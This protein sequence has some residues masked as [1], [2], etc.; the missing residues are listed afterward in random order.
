MIIS[1]IKSLWLALFEKI[2]FVPKEPKK[3]TQPVEDTEHINY[4]DIAA[5]KVTNLTCVEATNEVVSESGL[6]EPLMDISDK[7]MQVKEKIVYGVL[8]KGGFFNV[9]Y[10]DGTGR[11]Q[12]MSLTNDYVKI[13]SRDGDNIKEAYIILE[14]YT[15]KNQ[16]A[17]YFLM[18]H[19]VLENNGDLKIDYT[20][21][22]SS[23]EKTQL[24]FTN[25][26]P[27]MWKRNIDSVSVI[28]NAKHIGLGYYRSPVQGRNIPTDEGVPLDFG[29]SEIIAELKEL[30]TQLNNE[31][32]NGKS[33]IFADD[34]ILVND[35][36]EHRF[37]IIENIFPSHRKAGI[38]GNMIEVYSPSIRFQQFHEREQA[39]YADLEN[40]MKLSRG[41]FT[42]NTIT[43]GATATEVKRSNKDTI[44]LIKSLH[45]MLDK[46]DEM[47]LEACGIYLNIRRELWEYQS[48]YYDPFDDA[49]EQWSYLKAAYDTG[50]VSLKRLTK[51]IYPNMTDEEVEEELKAAASE[52]QTETN[53][54]IM[55]ALNM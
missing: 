5:G 48:D 17:T 26:I 3:D 50:A 12:L 19:H 41:I 55:Q 7:L 8:T 25:K 23:A 10:Y 43:T 21:M 1:K 37:K 18:R 46:G 49:G 34:R 36:K 4:L 13:V 44:A 47:T 27:D 31:F 2:G 53:S 33:L 45:K 15:P 40:Q 30:R 20:V 32:K 39:L 14:T 28:K 52:K 38:E 11:L 51:W 29:C 42:E 54:A 24:R 16:T 9:P 6:A 22:E 35:E